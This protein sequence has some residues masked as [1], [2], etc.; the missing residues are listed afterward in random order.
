MTQLYTC[1]FF[2][3]FFSIP[4][5]WMEF[6][7]RYSKTS[8]LM[9]SKCNSQTLPPQGPSPLAATS[10]FSIITFKPGAPMQD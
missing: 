10:L 6:P 4:G 8:L 2:F 1:T 7:E 3:I 5:D 9:H